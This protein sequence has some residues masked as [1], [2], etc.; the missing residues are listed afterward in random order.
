M[1]DRWFPGGPVVLVRGGECLVRE[2][3]SGEMGLQREG[4]GGGGGRGR[5]EG[6]CT[7]I[8]L[9]NTALSSV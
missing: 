8:A 4:E 9:S 5:R 2:F 6:L 3:E 7:C 1:R